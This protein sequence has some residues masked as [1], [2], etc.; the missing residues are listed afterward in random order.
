MNLF[1]EEDGSL[2]IHEIIYYI[3]VM[4]AFMSINSFYT[5]KETILEIYRSS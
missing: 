5:V 4:G 2:P 1:A 3:H